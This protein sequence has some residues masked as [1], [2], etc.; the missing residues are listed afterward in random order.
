MMHGGILYSLKSDDLRTLIEL[1]QPLFA[2]FVHHAAHL[3]II[4]ALAA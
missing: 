2:Q 4:E 3:I 1:E